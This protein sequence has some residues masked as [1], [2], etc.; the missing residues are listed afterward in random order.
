[1][2]F[3]D[4][5]AIV[6]EQ[7]SQALGALAGNAGI[8]VGTKL[9]ITKDFRI[10]KTE[11]QAFI[12][13]L[14]AT[15]GKA[16]QLRIADGDLS[17]TDIDQAIEANGPLAP[18]DST[19]VEQVMRFTKLFGISDPYEAS[20]TTTRV[21]LGQNNSQMMT[22]NPRWTFKETFSWDWH[23]FNNGQTLTTG[24]TIKI[25]AKHYGVWLS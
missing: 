4:G 5:G 17:A 15:E 1:M 23:V 16:L 9:A 13:G 20:A 11:I 24:A 19:L 25:L 14:T 2:A 8:I 22:E 21:F 10:L 18:G 6:T 12:S 7:R 3:K